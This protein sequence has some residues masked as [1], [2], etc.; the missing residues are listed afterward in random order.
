MSAPAWFQTRIDTGLQRLY[1]LSLQGSPAADVLAFTAETWVSVLYPARRWEQERDLPRLTEAF[2][3]LAGQVERWPTPK[4]LLDCMPAVPE[5]LALPAPRQRADPA[6]IAKA[7][8]VVAELALRFTT[9]P[10]K[11]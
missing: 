9:P 1:T 6:R 10:E 7:R 4:A 2:R 11:R 8:A 5:A 3:L